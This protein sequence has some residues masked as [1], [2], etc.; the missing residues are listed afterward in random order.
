MNNWKKSF[1]IIWAGQ[2]LSI[3]SSTIVNF[4]VI[5]WISLETESAEMLAWAAMAGILPQTILGPVTGVYVDRWNRKRIMMLSDS[6]IAICT[7]TLS[8]LFWFGTAQMWHLFIVLG[9]RSAGTAFHMPAMQASVPL[10][11]PT[12][13][14]TRIAGINQIIN[15]VANIAGPAL[16]ALFIS[17]WDIEYIL[18]LDVAGAAFAVTSLC[19]VVI[20]NPE[21]KCT[22]VPHI[23]RE[24]KEGITAV[25]KNRGLSWIF[26]FSILCTF[27]IMPVSVLFPLITLQHFGGNAF[28]ISLVEVAW[29]VGA[30]LGGAI[31]G[32]RVYRIN[33]VIFVNGTC[34]SLGFSFL[35]SGLLPSEGFIL[36][37]VLTVLGGISGAVYHSA[38]I[39]LVQTNIQP[40]AL[41]R[42]FSM[43]YTGSL[44]PSMIGLVGIGFFA[45]G[46]GITTTFIACGAI[47]MFF[48]IIAFAPPSVLRLDRR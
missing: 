22:A 46:L 21:K 36:F 24:M 42:V 7:L 27:F 13:Q 45:D 29:G 43:Y 47:L 23:F 26:L 33:R 39:S 6:F 12:D 9:L 37:V 44:I 38:F 20:P 28:Q 16:G 8:I 34:V 18:L 48:G 35:I 41:G 11:A 19:F 31:M 40:E 17:I 5:L 15:S 4:A 1:P 30:L 10:L 25:L 3:L 2:F 32:I 14:L